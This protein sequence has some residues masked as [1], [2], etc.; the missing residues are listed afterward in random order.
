MTEGRER[1]R[2]RRGEGG[3][4]LNGKVPGEAREKGIE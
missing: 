2:E 3:G 4:G 1:R